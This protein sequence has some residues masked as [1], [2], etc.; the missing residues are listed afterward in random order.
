M[1]SFVV[2]RTLYSIRNQTARLINELDKE[3][4]TIKMR[5][6]RELRANAS[7]HPDTKRLLASHI[8]I[9]DPGI[10][11]EVSAFLLES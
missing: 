9:T 11:A 3:T 4:L 6:L 7:V 10:R 2:T 5:V 8:P 1:L